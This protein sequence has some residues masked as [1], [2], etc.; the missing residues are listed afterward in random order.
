MQNGC[1]GKQ[2][3]AMTILSPVDGVGKSRRLFSPRDGAVPRILIESPA[4]YLFIRL[5]FP[6][7][8]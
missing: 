8:V 6:N 3:K 5:S 1:G 7:R 4:S 2:L